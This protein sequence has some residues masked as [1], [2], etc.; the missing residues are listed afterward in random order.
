MGLFGTKK[1]P[2]DI[3][4]EGKRLYAQGKPDDARFVFLDISGKMRGEGDYWIGRTYLEKNI[5]EGKKPGHLAKLYLKTS[6]GDGYLPSARLLAEH[7]GITSYLPA[8]TEPE[9]GKGAQKPEPSRQSRGAGS[10]NAQKQ[11]AGKRSAAEGGNPEEDVTRALERLLAAEEQPR[12]VEGGNPEEDAIHALER[13]LAGEKQPAGEKKEKSAREE[14]GSK[15][16]AAQAHS[17]PYRQVKPAQEENKKEKP[18]AQAHAEPHRQTRPA[19]QAFEE[20]KNAYAAGN[21]GQ[22]LLLFEEAAQQGHAASQLNC[23]VMYEDGEYT[24]QD[25]EKALYWYEKAAM[26]GNVTAQFS[27]G[28]MYAGGEGTN[29]DRAKALYWY[30]KAADQGHTAAKAACSRMQR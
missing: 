11:E 3:L 13:L 15:K 9:A 23:A 16:P 4:A 30:Q 10:G 21:Y 2:E 5:R 12:A 20:G 28:E 22:A 24:A 27:C 14:S 25:K 29:P 26:Q 17:E 19:A 6:A 1:S 18:A 8:G 7:Y